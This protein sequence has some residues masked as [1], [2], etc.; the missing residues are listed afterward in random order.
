M[1]SV[2]IIT[3]NF[4]LYSPVPGACVLVVVEVLVNSITYEKENL[5]YVH[6]KGATYSYGYSFYMAWFVFLINIVAGCVFMWYSRKR[7]GD[8]AASEEQ[9]LA[10]EPTII[11]R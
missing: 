2:V 9:A 3:I 11:G 1:C 6:P 7:K 5:P 10:D 8:K 4:M